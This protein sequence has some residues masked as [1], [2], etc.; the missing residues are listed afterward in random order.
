MGS[1]PIVSIFNFMNLITLSKKFNTKNRCYKHLEKVRWGNKPICP[2]CQSDSI[3]PRLA[4]KHYYHCNGC[5]TDFT[6]LF[7]TIFEDSK[8]PL[9]K[10]FLLIAMMLNARKGISSKQLERQLGVTWKNRSM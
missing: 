4:R 5:N 3:T 10:W 8:L 7:G 6:V 2:H 9:P 1:I